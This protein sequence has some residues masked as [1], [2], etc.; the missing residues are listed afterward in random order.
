MHI[1]FRLIATGI[2]LLLTALGVE[3]QNVNSDT[4]RLDLVH[5][6]KRFLEQNLQLLAQKFN[7]DAS[8]A[9]IIQARLW[10]NPN[11][12][13]SQ[14]AYNTQTKK[15]FQIA[16]PEN[17]EQAA[18][19]SQLLVLAGKIKK[20]TKIAETNY[21]LAEYGFYDLLRTL[22]L[23]LRSTFFNIYYLYQTSKVYDKEINSLKTIVSAFEEQVGNGYVSEADLAR[24]QA[25]LY[26][27]QSEYQA[28][29]DNINDQQSQIRLLLKQPSATFLQPVVD[30]A[31]I[32]ASDP[33]RYS[34][35]SMIDSAYKNRTDLMIAKGNLQLSKQVYSLQKA[36]SVPDLTMGF[37]FDRHGS[38][39]PNFNSV[40]LGIDIPLFN[41]N[42]GN[43]KSTRILIEMNKTQ[44]E[45][46]QNSIEEQVSR[47]LQ[48]A[49]DA[50]KL[51]KQINPEFASHF[52]K[53][54]NAMLD[55]Y[56]Q[57][58]VRLLDFLTFYDSYKQNIVQLNTIL[59]NKVNALENINFLT[60][61]NFFN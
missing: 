19:F 16:D 12:S 1:I 39:I 56:R 41:R 9:L 27:L 37:G 11:I 5:S 60:G 35:K 4:L 6:E 18:Q 22:K 50:Q 58:L 15:W 59:F 33:F 24:V 36:L 54:A 14:G 48:K 45:F 38:Y 3:A 53:L 43:I 52:D 7:V 42:Q 26:S 10:P 13:I 46:T 32:N 2:L 25:Q 30:T 21:Q 49:V 29:I 57:R 44:L 61:T 17:A 40:N 20:Q 31:G 23:S 8:R 51:Y 28:L 34:L 47:G 55:N